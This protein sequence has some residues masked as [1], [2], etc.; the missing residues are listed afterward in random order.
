MTDSKSLEIFKEAIE[1]TRTELTAEWEKQETRNAQKETDPRLDALKDFID[2]RIEVLDSLAPGFVVRNK[3]NDD[4]KDEITIKTQDNID[5]FEL[6]VKIENNNSYT[7]RLY[8]APYNK[9]VAIDTNMSPVASGS[10][11]N[12]IKEKT[13]PSPQEIGNLLNTLLINLTRTVSFKNFARDTSAKALQE[14]NA[15]NRQ[16]ATFADA[17]QYL[18]DANPE[19]YG[20]FKIG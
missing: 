18:A 2:E 15:F 1:Q 20:H 19:K 9:R 7:I 17:R 10:I 13:T 3:D 16:E 12:I 6:H 5:F 11:N 8:T 4:N 14:Q